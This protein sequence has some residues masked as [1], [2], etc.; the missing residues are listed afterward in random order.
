MY[1]LKDFMCIL[2]EFATLEL[3]NKLQ[4]KGMY[5]NSGII[6]KCKNQIKKVV[7]CLDLTKKSVE[8]AKRVKADTIV[9]HHPAIYMPIKSLSIQDT[10]T[11]PILLAVKSDINIISMHLNLDIALN[12]IDYNLCKALG[13]NSYK[14]IQQIT[15][16]CGYGKEFNI[17]KQE[18]TDFVKTIR[19]QFSTKKILCYKAGKKEIEKVA[20]FCGSGGTEALQYLKENQQTADVIVTS[21]IP[22]HIIKEILD[23]DKSLIIIP[24]Y[25]SEE[26]GFKAFY[27][28]IT[29]KTKDLEFVY[30]NDKRFI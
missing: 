23:M 11:M 27:N 26:Y 8:F 25:V 13:G 12:G 20:S 10:N 4:E 7:F 5:D 24:H 2:E 17:E 16:C 21:D 22:H 9:T 1:N 15:Q 6:L 30:F 18:I 3:S 29:Q 28:E 19:K 14:N